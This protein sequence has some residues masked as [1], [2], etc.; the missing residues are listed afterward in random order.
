MKCISCGFE[1]NDNFC[2]N[3][4]E[5]KDVKKLNFSSIFEYTFLSITNMDKG[6]LFNLKSLIIDPKKIVTEY[7]QGKRKNILN[8]ISFLILSVSIYIITERF[9][10]VPYKPDNTTALENSIIYKMSYYGGKF[11]K[12]YFNFFWIL[13]IF[14]LSL[15]TK[16]LFRKFNFTEHLV[17]NSFIFG[18]VTLCST[19]S[20]PIFKQP[21]LFD[22][23]MYLSLMILIYRVYKTD[24]N[25]LETA[26]LSFIIVFLFTIILFIIALLL[27]YIYSSF[28]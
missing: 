23:I 11:V 15:L 8:P 5:K 24:H 19:L 18:F 20:Y 27:G 26:L 16:V 25:K 17:I 1:H 3:C 10:K 22:F 6:F 7:T 14:P 28:K 21:L 12:T 13:S 2:P 9:F 4:G